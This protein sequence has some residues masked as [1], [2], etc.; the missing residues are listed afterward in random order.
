MIILSW[1]EAMW[2][3]YLGVLIVG[4]LQILYKKGREYTEMS[5]TFRLLSQP[6]KW[7]NLTD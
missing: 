7:F 5:P 1:G 6:G 3:P 2:W 4:Y